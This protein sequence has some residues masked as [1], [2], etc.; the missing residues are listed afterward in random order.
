M[1]YGFLKVCAATPQIKVAD[2]EF[3]K[4]SILESIKTAHKNKVKVAV[5]PELCVTGAACGDLFLHKPL[6]DGAKNAVL[7]IAEGTKKTDILCII[8]A[9]LLIDG[10]VYNCAVLIK[11]GRILA[12]IPQISGEGFA[13]GIKTH[14]DIEFGG[15]TV[16]FGTDILVRGKNLDGFLLAAEIGRDCL[17]PNPPSANAALAGATVIAGLAASRANAEES[18][19]ACDFAKVQSARLHTAIICADAGYGDATTDFVL[20]GKNMLFE[21]GRLLKSGKKF[22]NDMIISEIDLELLAFSRRKSGFCKGRGYYEVETEFNIEETPLSRTFEKM[23]FAECDFEEAISIQA[24]ALQKRFEHTGA[25]KAVIGVSGGL[26]STMALLVT[27]RAFDKLALPRKNILAVTMP[28]FGTTKRTRSNAQI[29]AEE[30]G[31]AFKEISIKDAVN[32]HFKD[33][34]QPADKFDAAFE[35]AQARERTQVLMD[36]ANQIGGIVVGTG[37]MSELALGWAT[38][39]GDHM[40]MYGVNCGVPKTLMRLLVEYEADRIGNKKLKAALSDILN[41]PV[42]PEL[43]PP[44][45]GEIAQKTEQTVGPYLLHD[46]FLYNMLY[47]GSSPKKLQYIAEYAFKDEF[48]AEEIKKWLKVFVKRFF[49]Q[50][51]KRSCSPDGAQ[52]LGISLSPRGGLVMPSD[53]QG[54][55]WL[56]EIEE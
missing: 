20:S 3:N 18:N 38:Y 53:A 35:N 16:P 2:C 54:E 24:A 48:S 1:K 33:I 10:A 7:S 19:K 23:P 45:K 15:Q 56:V 37:D 50:Q 47:L 51:F 9:P 40:S 17:L 30:L 49:S 22:E 34:G 36:I 55:M 6:L 52:V 27:A 5:F 42:S 44:D 26:D 31:A 8:G 29:T 11:S 25:K 12:I 21:D 39:N 28:C 43:L 14:E 32:Q 13:K 46:F 4:K 41:T